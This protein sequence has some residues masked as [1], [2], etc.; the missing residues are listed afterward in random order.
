MENY[1]VYMHVTPNKKVYIGITCRKPQ[2][3]WCN[4]TGYKG[5]KHFYSAIQKYGWEN[6]EHLIIADGL[7][8]QEAYSLEKEL[9]KKHDATN[10]LKGYNNSTGGGGGALGVKYSEETIKKR[11]AHRDYS[12][13]WAKGKH[14]TEEHRRKISIGRKGKKHTEE[15]KQKMREAHI[16]YI[17]VWAGKR[18]ND[19]YR[20]N[21]SI[22]IICVE[23]GM[24]YFGTMEA[25][26]Q[27][28]IHHS[29]IVNCL[30]GKRNK[31]GGYHWEY[32]ACE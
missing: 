2:Y 7:S 30:K 4:G 3:R 20:A 1:T 11:L 5:N 12:N 21:K 17:P 31:A 9:I 25:E 13:S 23:T 10:P 22:P 28:G 16:G 27:T 26:R 32:A 18:R 19:E 14:F 24:R 8:Q 29:N 6:I 15:S